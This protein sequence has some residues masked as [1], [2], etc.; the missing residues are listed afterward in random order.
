VI[1]AIH[2]TTFSVR[3]GRDVIADV[4]WV[5][6]E[7]L[8]RLRTSAKD[9]GLPRDV[10]PASYLK[11]SI[12]YELGRPR[13]F[14]ERWRKLWPRLKALYEAF[15]GVSCRLGPEARLEDRLGP[16]ARLE[17]DDDEALPGP[18]TGFAVVGKHAFRRMTGSR[19][20]D[21]WPVDLVYSGDDAGSAVALLAHGMDSDYPPTQARESVLCPKYYR[22]AKNGRLQAR[23]FV[24]DAAVCTAPH[25]GVVYG[26][27]DV[28]LHLLYSQFLKAPRPEDAARRRLAAA[29]DVLVGTQ[30]LEPCDSG[31]HRRFS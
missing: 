12:H 4:S 8:A 18:D 25:G 19:L 1:P 16:E 30:L 15:P 10:V 11:M 22:L 24:S 6:P 7:C 28:V 21:D 17:P 13:V 20:L 29:I 9:E 31:I 23:V 2:K 5:S 27:S 3:M 14:T 26:S